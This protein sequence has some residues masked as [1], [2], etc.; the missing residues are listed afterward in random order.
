MTELAVKEDRTDA[1][2]I[3]LDRSEDLPISA[4]NERVRQSLSEAEGMTRLPMRLI[5]KYSEIA[6]RH[7]TLKRAADAEWFAKIPGFLGVWAKEGSREETLEVLQEVVVDWVLL[8][9]E[10]KDRDLPVVEEIDLNVL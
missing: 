9:I 8:K 4:P 3:S 10:H 1:L 5:E 2:E 6:V 7:A